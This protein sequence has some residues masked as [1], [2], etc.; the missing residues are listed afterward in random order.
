M[1]ILYIY[2]TCW[3]MKSVVYEHLHHWVA[4]GD[5]GAVEKWTEN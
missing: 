5:R 3:R 4:E 2:S 1:V